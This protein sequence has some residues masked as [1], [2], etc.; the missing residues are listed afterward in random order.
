MSGYHSVFWLSLCAS[1]TVLGLVL[2]VVAGR[3]RSARAMLHGAAWSLIPI[4]AY[5]TGATLMLWRI[6]VAIGQFASS[7]VFSPLRWAGIGV[8]AL[9]VVLF[10]AGGGRRRRKAARQARVARREQREAQGPAGPAGQVP[11]PGSAGAVTSGATGAGT[12]G[13]PV[14]E[15]REPQ[16]RARRERPEPGRKTPPGQQASPGQQAQP[17]KQGMGKNEL[18]DIEEI[19]RKRGI[20]SEVLEWSARIAAAGVAVTITRL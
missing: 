2:T 12:A 4:A 17:G 16:P 8:T 1:L 3:R 6:G 14:P 18:A 19:L 20:L 5:M 7:F 13:G 10:L 11:S 9:V 15:A